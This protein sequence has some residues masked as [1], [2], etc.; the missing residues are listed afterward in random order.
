MKAGDALDLVKLAGLVG[1]VA[2]VGVVGWK[3]YKG[4][5][6]IGGAVGDAFGAVGDAVGGAVDYVAA[7]PG[8]V[9][10]AASVAIAGGGDPAFYSSRFDSGSSTSQ[11]L[12]Q[13]WA[14]FDRITGDVPADVPTSVDP[15]TGK[16]SG[17]YIA[18]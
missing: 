12:A 5:S 15:F 8:R 10:D 6:A 11:L 18:P 17:S 7:I 16:I 2:L 4:A 13:Q 1:A 14:E 9:A 3:V